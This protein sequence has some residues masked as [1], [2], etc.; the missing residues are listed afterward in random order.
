MILAAGKG[1]R[2]YPLT[3][4]LPKPMMPI[5]KRPLLEH[6]LINL[7]SQGIKDIIINLHYKPD[8]ITKYLG[9]GSQLELNIT[10]SYEPKILGTAG[11]IKKV[12]KQLT[13]P[14]LVVYGDNFSK[15]KIDK[16]SQFHRAKQSL[17]TI[18]LSK[19]ADPT[20]GGIATIDENNRIVQ[21]LEKPKKH[22]VFSPWINAGIYIVEPELL[23]HIPKNK[24]YDFGHDLFPKLLQDHKDIFGYP[25]PEA[26]QGINNINE[27]KDARLLN[28]KYID[29]QS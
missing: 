29:N 4:F 24:Q 23:K 1:T 28:E 22:Q 5:G 10:Y 15:F 27:Y 13:K 25:L 19:G 11:A 16:L 21:F 26:L 3:K 18:A 14:F 12:E 9:D 20:S 17:A 7:K 6:I 2:L 8:I